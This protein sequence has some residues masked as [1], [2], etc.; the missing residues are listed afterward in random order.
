MLL[1]RVNRHYKPLREALTQRSLR[2]R[3]FNECA[4]YQIFGGN[5]LTCRTRGPK[6]ADFYIAL[7]DRLGPLFFYLMLKCVFGC[8]V[9]IPIWRYPQ[10]PLFAS[11]PNQRVSIL[12]F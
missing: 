3:D 12:R 8:F 1:G 5:A 10:P 2:F 11:L 4:E 9:C 7:V 6:D